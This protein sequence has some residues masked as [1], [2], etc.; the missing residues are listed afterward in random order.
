MNRQLVLVPQGAEFQA[1]QRGL[2]KARQPKGEEVELRAL[3]MGMAAVQSWLGKFSPLPSPPT[4][5]LVLGVCGA[6]VPC[7]GVG[8]VVVYGKCGNGQ[9]EW[10]ICDPITTVF[11]GIDHETSALAPT[12]W[13]TV[14]ALTSDRPLCTVA[15]KATWG[16]K[17]GAE[18]VDM[19]GFPLVDAFSRQ[20]LPITIVRVVS[21][22]SDR[23]IPDL[24]P[25][26]APDGS[27]RPLPLLQ[28]FLSQP[29]PAWHLI[30]GSLT[31]L[32]ILEKT[33]TQL[34]DGK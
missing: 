4:S 11:K 17:T 2:G 23:P 8:Q 16:T 10:Q 7:Y 14:T 19:E 34:F 31:A 20:G 33:V 9:G 1:V 27:L 28:A 12:S 5:I 18:V 26:I 3:P 30:Q 15:E 13:P 32:G 25:A 29:L 6:L 22:A 24:T 21:D